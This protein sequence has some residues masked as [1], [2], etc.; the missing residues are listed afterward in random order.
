M[1]PLAISGSP[2]E[3]LWYSG[4]SLS[5]TEDSPRELKVC[6]LSGGAKASENLPQDEGVVEVCLGLNCAPGPDKT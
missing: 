4:L 2:T 6:M 1:L 3:N 5:H